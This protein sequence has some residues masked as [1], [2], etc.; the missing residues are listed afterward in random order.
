MANE[1]PTTIGGEIGATGATA[2]TIIEVTSALGTSVARNVRTIPPYQIMSVRG[3]LGNNYR[4]NWVA[5]FMDPRES[6]YTYYLGKSTDFR[7]GPGG[8]YLNK[9]NLEGN[10][11]WS[12]MIGD[13]T[14]NDPSYNS[15][16]PVDMKMDAN[17]WIYV[18]GYGTDPNGNSKIW[19]ARYNDGGTQV[20]QAWCGID[21]NLNQV[22][23]CMT[24]DATSGAVY[25]GGDLDAGTGYGG[26]FVMRM[27][28]LNTVAPYLPKQ[29][30][31]K[32]WITNGSFSNGGTQLTGIEL[33]TITG[34]TT[35][36]LVM[37][38]W[39]D[40]D[41]PGYN[42]IFA[43]RVDPA[44][45]NVIWESGDRTVEYLVQQ[46]YSASLAIADNGEVYVIGRST[47]NSNAGINIW[48]FLQ[49]GSNSISRKIDWD[50]DQASGLP[51]YA[52]TI[53]LL[54]GSYGGLFINGYAGTE[55]EGDPNNYNSRF[56]CYK[57]NTSDLTAAWGV[58]VQLVDTA[59]TPSRV[60]RTYCGT[61]SMSIN[62]SRKM[63]T[64]A[65]GV[66]YRE[67][68]AADPVAVSVKIP[69]YGSLNG[70]YTAN[71]PVGTDYYWIY[72]PL[73]VTTTDTTPLF[74]NW[75]LNLVPTNKTNTIRASTIT[76]PAPYNTTT[77]KITLNPT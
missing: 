49:D 62:E 23:K 34:E 10:L 31:F 16:N 47:L 1:G 11:V 24:V 75:G 71:Y 9:Y 65:G 52:G 66:N 25:I 69:L 48:K 7:K 54:T 6:L 72:Q 22:P 64:W 5:S 68:I 38:G 35:P 14:G 51:L 19:L 76:Y 40:T 46:I 18:C 32:S 43:A 21:F 36:R 63:I 12:K 33:K 4:F 60:G 41:A 20:F 26:A 8:T 58:S 55:N 57:I 29:I 17:G 13:E 42:N 39:T 67:G 45:G 15:I 56:V 37:C 3:D 27:N 70:N 30:W 77:V 44:N 73:T 50:Y 2:K 61:A 74:R 53:K 59:G 28:A